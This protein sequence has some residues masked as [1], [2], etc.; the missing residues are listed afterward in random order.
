MKI[1]IDGTGEELCLVVPRL[2]KLI[3]VQSADL[4]YPDPITGQHRFFA[5][6]ELIQD[7]Q[8]LSD[9]IYDF[10]MAADEKNVDVERFDALLAALDRVDPLPEIQASPY[11]FERLKRQ[12]QKM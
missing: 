4:L 1:T 12:I 8:Q 7:K 11:F 3:R 2:S 9:E 10:I 6:G 5:E